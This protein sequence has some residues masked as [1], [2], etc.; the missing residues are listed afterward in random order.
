MKLTKKQRNIELELY[1]NFKISKIH[2]L[3]FLHSAIYKNLY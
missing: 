2:S 3:I 1:I